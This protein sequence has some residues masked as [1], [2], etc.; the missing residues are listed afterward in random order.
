VKVGK[1]NPKKMTIN[2]KPKIKIE[3]EEYKKENYKPV[4]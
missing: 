2:Y 1:I 4:A 3:V